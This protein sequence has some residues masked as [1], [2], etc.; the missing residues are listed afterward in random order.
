[1]R[2]NVKKSII[3]RL[4]ENKETC[5]SYSPSPKYGA[6]EKRAKVIITGPR[7]LLKELIDQIWKA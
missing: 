4:G 2:H 5:I 7:T 1:M 6:K 3:E